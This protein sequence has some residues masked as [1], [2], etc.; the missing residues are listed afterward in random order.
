LRPLVLREPH[1]ACVN[2]AVNLAVDVG[3]VAIDGNVDVVAVVVVVVVDV[4]VIAVVV[5]DVVVVAVI[6]HVVVISEGN[7]VAVVPDV[8]AVL[9]VVMG[10]SSTCFIVAKRQ[11]K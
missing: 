8:V 11:R 9:P 2:I 6:R 3:A 4:V 7:T 5:V 1:L 10:I